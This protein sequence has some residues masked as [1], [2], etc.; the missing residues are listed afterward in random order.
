MKLLHF[1]CHMYLLMHL[2]IIIYIFV[3]Y[4]IGICIFKPHVLACPM[5][6]L[7]ITTVV[8]CLC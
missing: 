5:H 2:Y 3:S 4:C 1:Y 7:S 6:P 8:A